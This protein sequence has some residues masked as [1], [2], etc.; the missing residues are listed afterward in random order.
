M[1]LQ[2]RRSCVRAGS[3][4]TA[5]PRPPQRQHRRRWHS[6]LVQPQTRS[7]HC[8]IQLDQHQAGIHASSTV[9]SMVTLDLARQLTLPRS[10]LVRAP[11]LVSRRH[12]MR[13]SPVLLQWQQQQ[14]Q[15]A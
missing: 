1:Q 8:N 10:Q 3:E 12:S 11:H 4:A 6:P 15:Q 14:Q 13:Q 9:L 5:R 2:R 7:L